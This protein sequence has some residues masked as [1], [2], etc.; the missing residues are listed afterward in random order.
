MK[1]TKFIIIT[2]FL[3]S[4]YL[5]VC[6]QK[7]SIDIVGQ[8]V[9]NNYI[10]VHYTLATTQP[11]EVILQY[12]I[13]NGKF[14]LDCKSVTGDLKYQ[15]SGNK[16]IFWDC[17]K[18]GW[19]KGSLLFRVIE[20]DPKLVKNEEEQNR[21][22]E[23]QPLNG[24]YFT[25]GS[26]LASSGYYGIVGLGYEYRH[27]I[28]GINFSIG[29]GLDVWEHFERPRKD[30]YEPYLYINANA[31]FKLYFANKAKFA[32][33]LYLNFL[34]F[35]YFGQSV[36]YTSNGN[37]IIAR[38]P[39]LYGVGLFLGYAPVFNVGKEGKRVRFGLNMTLGVKTNYRFDTWL[40]INGD[41][42]FILKFNNK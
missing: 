3:I 28:L 30:R 17:R 36:E 24:S 22:F 13:D 35:S 15:T 14:W 23:N 8:E 12:S 42:G 7:I 18:D 1:T 26:S 4:C 38:C 25:W 9:Q 10:A 32:R 21:R 41:F 6:A 2:S 40:P 29:L 20:K 11:V 39:H 27:H 5:Q 16:T 34:P 37:T 19:E 33:N 31:G